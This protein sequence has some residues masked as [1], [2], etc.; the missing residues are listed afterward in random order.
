M[1]V[2]VAYFVVFYDEISSSH[3]QAEARGADLRAELAEAKQAE[4]EYQ[5]DL[6]E[7][8]ERQQRQRELNK[9]LPETT[10]YPAFSRRCRASPTSPASRCTAWTPQEEVPQ[11]FYARVPMKLDAAR[12]IPPGG[13]VLLRRGPA[14]SHHQHREH[15]DR[16]EPKTQND[17]VDA[18]G[19]VPGHGVSHH[20]ARRSRRR[21]TACRRRQAMSARATASTVWPR[22]RRS[23]ARR[24][25]AL[26]A[27]RAAAGGRARRRCRRRRRPRLGRGRRPRRGD[28]ERIAPL[29]GANSAKTTSPRPSTA[30]IRSG[31]S[32]SSSSEQGKMRVKSQR[33][34][35]LD[36]YAVDELKLI[37][38]VTA[39]TRRGPCWSTRPARAGW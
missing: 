1:L 9:I 13:E 16:A 25:S 12:Q 23:A 30:A 38:I 36:Q 29:P 11:K 31:R 14:R 28:A 21:Q 3:R 2:G 34:V 26:L 19:R 37:G 8:T 32:P 18:E 7:L 22:M 33:Q 24:G 6:A 10:E 20:R 27:V 35:L 39:P 4:F 15:R 5:K 17:E